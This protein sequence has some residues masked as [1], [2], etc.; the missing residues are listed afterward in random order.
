MIISV[1]TNFII[2]SGLIALLVFW[3]FPSYQYIISWVL[4]VWTVFSGMI[5]V[6]DIYNSPKIQYKLQ[7]INTPFGFKNDCAGFVSIL[8]GSISIGILSLIIS[9]IL[10]LISLYSAIQKTGDSKHI[11]PYDVH[12]KLMNYKISFIAE[13]IAIIIGV[14][15]LYTLPSEIGAKP[16]EVSDNITRNIMYLVSSVA[17]LCCVVS[18][19]I[20]GVDFYQ[21]GTKYIQLVSNDAKNLNTLPT[22]AVTTPPS[23]GDEGDEEEPTVKPTPTKKTVPLGEM[24]YE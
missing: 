20:Y 15:A 2:F 16:V 4:F 23:G 1:L 8:F 10:V 11:M 19:F 24:C 21:N 3:F 14:G 22:E 18:L 13:F 9:L 7:D 12:M 17:I 6:T 5:T